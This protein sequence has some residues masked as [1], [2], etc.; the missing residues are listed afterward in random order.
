MKRFNTKRPWEECC[1]HSARNLIS[2][3]LGSALRCRKSSNFLTFSKKR[4]RNPIPKA[5]DF[6]FKCDHLST[7][8]SLLDIQ[9]EMTLIMT[10]GNDVILR[11]SVR[12]LQCE[13][14]MKLYRCFGLDLI[15]SRWCESRWVDLLSCLLSQRIS[16]WCVSQWK[17]AKPDELMDSKLRCVFELPAENDKT[18]STCA[19]LHSLLRPSLPVFIS[20][21][22]EPARHTVYRLHLNPSAAS[23]HRLLTT[24]TCVLLSI[25]LFSLLLLP[26]YCKWDVK[27]K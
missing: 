2:S 22:P 16:I 3:Y 5:V 24:F 13:T 21:H 1:P 27:D 10:L 23:G 7:R 15:E 4:H 20:L 18:V 25:V 26:P 6:D 9:A 17:E 19:P 12:F 11:N 8:Y 14:N